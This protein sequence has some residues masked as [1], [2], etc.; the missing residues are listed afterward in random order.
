M[1]HWQRPSG[2]LHVVKNHFE[3]EVRWGYEGYSFHSNYG[4][5]PAAMLAT[6]VLFGDCETP[7]APAPVETGSY[8]IRY[9]DPFHKLVAM[10][11]G[12]TL[13]FDFD[14]DGKYDVTGLNSI[15]KLGAHPLLGPAT[16]VPAAPRYHVP[17]LPGLAIGCGLAWEG[18]SLAGSRV[19]SVDVSHSGGADHLEITL[20]Y[21]LAEGPDVDEHI[22]LR[23]DSVIGEVSVSRAHGAVMRWPFLRSDGRD[24]GHG[25]LEADVLTWTLGGS[26]QRLRAKGVRLGERAY[27][28]RNGEHIVAEAPAPDGRTAWRID[29]E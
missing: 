6:A 5:Y 23:S 8:A 2:E 4:L 11:K 24:T 16:G 15:R 10:H 18:G 3:P 14:A 25:T 21:A 19:R 12:L 28:A 27:A 29:Y 17:E 1:L 22:T 7:E 20:R 9:P 26:T 13:A